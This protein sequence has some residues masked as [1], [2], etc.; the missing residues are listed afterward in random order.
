MTQITGISC[1]VYSILPRPCRSGQ[2]YGGHCRRG[3]HDALTTDDAPPR[4]IMTTIATTIQM[5]RT[6][7]MRTMMR[8]DKEGVE[9]THGDKDNIDLPHRRETL[10]S[11]TNTVHSS[12]L[13]S[14]HHTIQN[15]GL[16]MRTFA[17]KLGEACS[18]HSPSS[19]LD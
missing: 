17:S 12:L 2:K 6:P 14:L 19:D 11:R 16:A 1:N 15:N 8:T 5:V 13:P 10:P 7:P 3:G 9:T 4:P 18:T